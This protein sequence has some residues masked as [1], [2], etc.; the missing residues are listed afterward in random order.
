MGLASVL[1]GGVT[2]RVLCAVRALF[3]SPHCEVA[4]VKCGAEEETA[5]THLQVSWPR[6]VCGVSHWGLFAQ[7]GSLA[8]SL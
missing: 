3:H 1:Q 2:L 7:E 8:S 5:L 6:L 4:D